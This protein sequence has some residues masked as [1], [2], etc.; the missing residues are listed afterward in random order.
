MRVAVRVF[1]GLRTLLVGAVLSVAMQGT[2]TSR[3]EGQQERRWGGP[4]I[5]LNLALGLG[6]GRV[7]AFVKGAGGFGADG[8]VATALRGGLAFRVDL[9][10]L[11]QDCATWSSSAGITTRSYRP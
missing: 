2:A 1:N 9:S 8:T 3:L 5:R 11:L 10:G 7:Q 4:E 6:R